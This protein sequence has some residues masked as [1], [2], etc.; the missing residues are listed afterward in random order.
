MGQNL[1]DIIRST[2]SIYSFNLNLYYNSLLK[3][4]QG[5]A[6][7]S[8]EVND[9]KAIDSLSISDHQQGGL[10]GMSRHTRPFSAH[11]Q[12]KVS[13]KCITNAST[14]SNT[15]FNLYKRK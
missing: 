3:Y 11:P 10:S 6:Q 2:V 4:L 7:N 13:L 14:L 1:S 8:G 12:P 5:L 15:Y 9:T